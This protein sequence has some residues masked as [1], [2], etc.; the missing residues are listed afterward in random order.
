MTR[1]SVIA[2]AL[3]TIVACT[4][5]TPT[6]PSPSTANILRLQLDGPSSIPPGSVAQFHVTA[7]HAD[8]THEDVTGQAV[9]SS[10][11]PATLQSAGNGQ[12]AALRDGEAGL[13]AQYARLLARA[14]VLVIE[15]GTWSLGGS[16]QDAP[17]FVV[18]G[19]RVEVVAG[20]GTGKA[21]TTSETGA[22]RLYGVAGD[23]QIRTTADG[24]Q[25]NILT[26]RVNGNMFFPIA[27]M[28]ATTP[29]DLTGRWRL[30]FDASPAC[31]ALSDAVQHRSYDATVEQNGA[32]VTVHLSGAS[33][34]GDPDGPP[35]KLENEFH[36][37]VSGDTV[38]VRLITYD[39]YGTHFDLG[40][41]IAGDTIYHVD[42]TGS[43]T[44]TSASVSGPFT[45]TITENPR[46]AKPI[47]CQRPDHRFTFSRLI[48]SSRR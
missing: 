23:V 22:F 24:Y 39:Y 34:L 18:S 10:S 40:E 2:A 30:T 19:A 17:G 47:T 28:P 26:T 29:S 36:G 37:R 1:R 41:T 43:A 45:G 3:V 4:G 5:K 7:F 14:T 46:N 42:G 6:A 27:L 48:S 32:G 9:W 15:P 13:T 33:F 44:V 35:G 25:P 11:E 20:T 8:L 38:T 12:V 21:A 31:T 16:V